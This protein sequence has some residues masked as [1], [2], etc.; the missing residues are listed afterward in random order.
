MWENSSE[1]VQHR[2][3]L[4]GADSRAFQNITLFAILVYE[5]VGP[6]LTKMA[7]QAAGEI[8]PMDDAVKN[9]RKI[10]LEKAAV[11]KK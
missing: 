3:F 11:T 6:L 2:A 1:E 5:L 10:N 7:L 9:R 8:V 4:R